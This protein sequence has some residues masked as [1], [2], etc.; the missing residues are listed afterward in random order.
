[1]WAHPK[2]PHMCLGPG[3]QRPLIT[4]KR[5]RVGLVLPGKTSAY[6]LSSGHCKPGIFLK[7][8]IA[9]APRKVAMRIK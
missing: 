7:P 1:M 9:K 5:V 8:L 4:G 3:L 2:S 6:I